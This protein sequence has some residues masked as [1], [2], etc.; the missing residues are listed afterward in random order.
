[1]SVFFWFVSFAMHAFQVPMDV[2][3]G[4]KSG[5]GSERESGVDQATEI[6]TT[7]K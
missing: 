3:D 1:M 4:A 6:S 5:N 7:C 2:D